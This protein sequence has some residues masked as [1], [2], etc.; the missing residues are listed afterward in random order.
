MGAT[1]VI[2]VRDGGD[3]EKQS[4]SQSTLKAEP[5][6]FPDRIGVGFAEIKESRT[7]RGVEPGQLE[8]WSCH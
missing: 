6:G 3:G 7:T 5:T 4:H 8:R 2:W 1:V